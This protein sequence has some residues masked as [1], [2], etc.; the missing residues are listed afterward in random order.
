MKVLPIVSLCMCLVGTRP[1][2]V[3]GDILLYNLWLLVGFKMLV[4]VA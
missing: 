2:P 3:T 1:P 4:R